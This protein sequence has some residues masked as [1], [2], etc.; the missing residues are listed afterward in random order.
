MPIK[1]V[2]EEH[3]TN[4]YDFPGHTKY[5]TAFNKVT[6]IESAKKILKRIKVV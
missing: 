5:E 3:T 6:D 2:S 1:K 4:H